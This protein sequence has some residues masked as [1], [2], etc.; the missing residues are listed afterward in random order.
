[1]DSMEMESQTI[2]LA[3]RY[4]VGSGTK[5]PRVLASTRIDWARFLEAGIGNTIISRE[6]L[7][8]TWIGQAR[9]PSNG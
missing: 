3:K 9:F 1:M 5:N 4:W 2:L 6:G 8:W 7:T